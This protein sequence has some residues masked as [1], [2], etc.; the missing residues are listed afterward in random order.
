VRDWSSDVCSSDL[1]F[2]ST[3]P[4]LPIPGRIHDAMIHA[5]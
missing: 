2:S 3:T 4:V 1:F 5:K